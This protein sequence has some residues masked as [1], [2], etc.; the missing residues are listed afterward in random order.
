[1][2]GTFALDLSKFAAKAGGNMDLVVRKVSL[3]LMAR[4]IRRTPV[5]TGR[6]RANWQVAIETI[7]VGEV[8]GSDKSG[9]K[10][11]TAAA[12]TVQ[13]MIAG[14]VVYLVNNVPYIGVLEDGSSKQAPAGMLEVTLQ[15]YPGIVQLAA[16]EVAR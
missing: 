12:A 9:A 10:T 1:M 15:E 5:D 4:V 16:S 6:A 7:P 3:D 13:S 2:A 14:H 11:L 8:E